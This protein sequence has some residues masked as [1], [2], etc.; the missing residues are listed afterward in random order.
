M[1]NV[2]KISKTPSDPYVRILY[3]QHFVNRTLTDN[4]IRLTRKRAISQSYE[5]H[6]YF[7]VKIFSAFSFLLKKRNYPQLYPR[8]SLAVKVRFTKYH[9]NVTPQVISL[10]S[11]IM[12]IDVLRTSKLYVVIKT[13]T[14]LYT[15]GTVDPR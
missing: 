1:G 4:K 2:S 10:V 7:H 3:K 13:E 9:E 5:L 15:H 8:D 14:R 11:A 6:I 12:H